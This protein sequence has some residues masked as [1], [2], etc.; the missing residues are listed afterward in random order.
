MSMSPLQAFADL[1]DALAN[2]SS[3]HHQMQ[4]EKEDAQGNLIT[5]WDA[6]ADRA[7]TAW[8]VLGQQEDA[9]RDI[10]SLLAVTY[11]GVPD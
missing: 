6:Q 8:D 11:G 4:G 3:L 5:L 10:K 9:L 7:M 2:M 1:T